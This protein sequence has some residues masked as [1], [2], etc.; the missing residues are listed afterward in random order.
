ME[1]NLSL[2]EI[3]TVKTLHDKIESENLIYYET[4]KTGKRVIDSV[5]NY[6]GFLDQNKK[7]WGEHKTNWQNKK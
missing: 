4:D 7:C 2:E 3:Q 5:K 1:N 6:Y